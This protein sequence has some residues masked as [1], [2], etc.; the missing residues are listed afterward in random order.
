[1]LLFGRRCRSQ[2]FVQMLALVVAVLPFVR[3]IETL[4][5]TLQDKDDE[6]QLRQAAEQAL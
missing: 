2:W 5:S 4:N 3:A 1:M 6:L